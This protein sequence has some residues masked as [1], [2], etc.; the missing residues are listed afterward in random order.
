MLV[1]DVPEE[2][3]FISDSQDVDATLES[4]GVDNSDGAYG[5]LFCIIGEGEYLAVWG[6]FG[7]VP[8]LDTSVD[9]LLG[10]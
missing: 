1:R 2:A 5:S 4:I 9:V 8:W 7:I 10:E 6:L 3:I